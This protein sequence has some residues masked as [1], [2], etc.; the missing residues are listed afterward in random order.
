MIEQRVTVAGL[1]I[2]KSTVS[3]ISLKL[4]WA[5]LSRPPLGRL[6]NL[7]SSSNELKFSTH[8]DLILPSRYRT[9]FIWGVL[10]ACLKIYSTT[11]TCQPLCNFPPKKYMSLSPFGLNL[12][13]KLLVYLTYLSINDVFKLSC[14]PSTIVPSWIADT[15]AWYFSSTTFVFYLFLLGVENTS[16]TV[17]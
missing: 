6:S 11:P 13:T 4:P 8:S 5:N 1:A 15:K 14:Y 9:C 2:T 17:L 7:V 3:I 16:A 12:L 10:I